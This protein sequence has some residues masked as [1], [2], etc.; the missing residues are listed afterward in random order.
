MNDD[1]PNIDPDL[2]DMPDLDKLALPAGPEHRPRILLLYGSNRE[3]SYSRL[4]VQEAARLLERFG[5]ETRI[6]NPSGLP[7]PDD[8]PDS[9][10]KVQELRELMQW[11]EG[12]VWCSP[13]RHGSMSAVFKAQ[14][15]WVPLAM[16]AVRPT[17]GKTLAIMQVSGGSQSFNALNQMRVLGRW[18]RMITIPN[19]SSVAKAFLEFDDA[20]RMKPSA[21]YDRVVDVME[22]LIKFTLLVRGR[23]D[24][25]VDR[26]SERKESAEALSRRVNQR[27]I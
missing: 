10:P 9:H 24:Y 4:L 20:G 7:L 26:Y 21:Y 16:G 13:E 12:Q 14:I 8:A 15:D 23:A 25:L 3:R 19:Q 11:S 1:L 6:F 2:L 27:S 17:Q 5:A 18:M 22:E